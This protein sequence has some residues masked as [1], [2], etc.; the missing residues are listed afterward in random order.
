[1]PDNDC[2]GMPIDVLSCV[3]LS[4]VGVGVGGLGVG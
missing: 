4:W 3:V 2:K 1:M